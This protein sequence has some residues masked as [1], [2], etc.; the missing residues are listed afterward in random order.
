MYKNPSSSSTYSYT[1][2]EHNFQFENSSSH[3][4]IDVIYILDP[5]K[6]PIVAVLQKNMFCF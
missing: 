3:I 1:V 2:A 6:E 4:L 5:Y